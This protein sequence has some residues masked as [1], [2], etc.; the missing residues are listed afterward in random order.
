[1]HLRCVAVYNQFLGV[2]NRIR[3]LMAA[4]MFRVEDGKVIIMGTECSQCQHRWFPPVSFGCERCGAYG[5]DLHARD[6]SS[7]GQIYAFTT[8]PER[9]GGMYTLAQVVLDDG[10]AIRAIISEPGPEKLAI[11]DRVE[12]VS[13][14]AEQVTFRKTSQ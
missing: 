3:V 11:G 12:G 8:V 7:T 5:D 2:V 9:D 1:M 10:P 14:G 6:L 4:K 13:D